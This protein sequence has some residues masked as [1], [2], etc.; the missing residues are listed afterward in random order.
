MSVLLYA[1]GAF[2]ALAG[3]A[4]IG[5][6]IPDNAFGIGNT[7]IMAGVTALVGGLIVAALGVVV[8]QLQRLAEALVSRT[9]VR[10][11]RPLDNMFGGT[12]SRDMT[13]VQFPA[14]PKSD[15]REPFSLEPRLGAPAP[16]ESPSD[17]GP[18][19]SFA[20]ALRN[21]EE[22]EVTVE[23]DV[24]LSPRHPM[25]GRQAATDLDEPARNMSFGHDSSVTEH[26]DE[27]MLDAS[28]RPSPRPAPAAPTPARKSHSTYF[29]AMWPA[30]SKPAK[31]PNIRPADAEVEPYVSAFEPPQHEPMAES[32][33]QADP[34]APEPEAQSVA[35][36]K[37]GVVDG[38][39]YTLYVDGSIE[40][41]LPQGTLRFASINELRSHLEKNA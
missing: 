29:D 6:G 23:D 33:S 36:L 38:M 14:K 2:A 5:F 8:A 16:A 39:G 17:E 7:L 24:S 25:A 13:G 26:R 41:E 32:A 31:E 40:A 21:P 10:P 11:S 30:E 37:S 35:I 19:H 22:S 34:E 27:P 12:G 15:A 1:V 4:M 28:W 20:P 3:V 18:A 9:P